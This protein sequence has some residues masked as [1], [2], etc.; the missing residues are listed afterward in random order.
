VPPERVVYRINT[1]LGLAEAAA[2][3]VG[4]V[5]LPCFIG[6]ANPALARLTPPQPDFADGIW[7]LTHADLR[8]TARVRA[9]MDFAGNEIAKQ[10]KVLEGTA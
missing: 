10:R 2:A 1:V 5:L 6:S 7:L 3:G 4:L 9:F 8:Q